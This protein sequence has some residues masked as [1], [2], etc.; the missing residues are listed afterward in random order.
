MEKKTYER[1]FDSPFDGPTK[2]F[3]ALIFC[4]NISS[5]DQRRL[6]RSVRCI[7]F[8]RGSW[9]GDLLIV[10]AEDLKNNRASEITV[11]RFKAK[12]V[13]DQKMMVNICFFAQSA[14]YDWTVLQISLHP[15]QS[16]ETETPGE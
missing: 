14:Q 6:H 15:P 13:D 8:T 10:D 1:R 4:H 9:I 5:N 2:P 11:K 16:P 3:G 7:F 12:E